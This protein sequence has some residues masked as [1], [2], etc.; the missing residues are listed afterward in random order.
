M[1]RDLKEDVGTT[2][3]IGP[4]IDETDGKTAETALITSDIDFNLYKNDA[5]KVD[6][7]L[8]PSGGDNDCAH[9]EDGYYSLELRDSDTNTPGY[10][11][12]TFQISGALIFHEDWNVLP[13][14][15]YDSRYSDTGYVRADAIRWG[16]TAITATYPMSD[17]WGITTRTLSAAT[18]LAIPT[19]DNNAT[20]VWAEAAR[21]LT[22][23]TNLNIPTSDNN[24]T[25]VWAEGTRTLT[26]GDNIDIPTSDNISAAVWAE[27]ARTL[28]A[29][30]NLN[31]PTSDA[32]ADAVWD[33]A[34]S[35]HVVAGGMGKQI[36]DI[37]LDTADL[38]GNQAAWATATGFSTHHQSDV[39]DVATR[40][41]TAATNLAIPTS[42]ANAT[43]VWAEGIRTLTAAT[44]LAIPTSDANATAVWAGVSRTLTTPASDFKA[45]GFST[46]VASDVWDVDIQK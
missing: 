32:N 5:T 26:A 28:T 24:A 25:A 39:W 44:N 9:V 7:T 11:R 36:S 29:A 31:I 12:G 15:V 4:F 45:T 16:G 43:A 1:S 22:A 23:A 46:H 35:G 19:S 2:V 33:E 30:T 38:Q 17:A 21:T 41:L 42:D 40:T 14:N 18:N 6:V 34:Q 8:T 13:A 20:A 37:L 3:I 10:L 27:A